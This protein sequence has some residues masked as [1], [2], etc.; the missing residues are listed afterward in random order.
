[1][2]SLGMEPSRRNGATDGSYELDKVWRSPLGPE[3]APTT[4]NEGWLETEAVG[5]VIILVGIVV[6]I[7]VIVVVVV[8]WRQKWSRECYLSPLLPFGDFPRE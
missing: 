3:G 7:V 8:Q 5:V 1:M 4:A 2:L 6:V